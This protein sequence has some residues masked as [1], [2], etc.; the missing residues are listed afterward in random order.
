M[1]KSGPSP[2]DYDVNP[3]RFQQNVEATRRYSQGDVH[4]EVA[5]RLTDFRVG[6]VLDVGCGEGR[7]A[8]PLRKQGLSVTAFDA[9]ITMLSALSGQRVLGDATALPFRTGAF[10]A[11]AALY[12]LYH[13]LQPEDALQECRRVLRQDGLF[14][15]CAPSRFND[16]E[17]ADV[18]P[19]GEPETFDAEN[20][21]ELVAD[22]FMVIE[23]QRW[24]A[25]LVH[26]PDRQALA[27]YLAGRGLAPAEIERACTRIKTPLDLTKRGMLI[28]GRNRNDSWSSRPS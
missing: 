24:D 27:L 2:A 26:L 3:N 7:L 22:Q 19:Y 28:Y 23:I 15:A 9:S 1:N 13:L 4:E 6:Q 10:G 17:L 18:L 25:P 12:M 20:G 16:P 14:V 21:P 11:V 8:R 5:E